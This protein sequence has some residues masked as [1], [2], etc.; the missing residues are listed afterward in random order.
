MR[1]VPVPVAVP[2][3]VPAPH[4]QPA[5]AA[6]TGWELSVRDTGRGFS[7]AQVA[8]VFEPFN[9][10][11]MEHEGIE[12]TGIGLTIVRD[13]VQRMGG[14][15]SVQSEPGQGSEFRVWWP[16]ADDIELP[17]PPSV[18]SSL[19][20]VVDP[21][22]PTGP[23]AL[24]RPLVML[25]IEDNPVNL[26]L[27]QELLAQRPHI[28]LLCAADGTTGVAMA[29][30]H[31]PDVILID[32][33]LPDFDGLEVLKRLKAVASTATSRMIALSANAMPDDVNAALAAGFNDY[34]TKPIDMKK[35][36]EKL[37]ALSLH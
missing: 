10:L 13:L 2:A 7:A 27:V 36:L 22:H 28:R 24:T 1:R 37:D 6:K 15:I 25:Y 5:D 19:K 35:V 9:R 11:G 18:Q 33:Q 14:H 8:L 17:A 26:L 32:M 20:A 31:L 30:S 16:A 12:G 3:P 34:W 4:L 21:P 29:L 23:T